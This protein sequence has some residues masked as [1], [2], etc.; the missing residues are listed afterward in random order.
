MPPWDDEEDLLDDDD[1]LADEEEEEWVG[2]G[3]EG[4]PGFRGALFSSQAACYAKFRP[5]YP[6]QVRLARNLFGRRKYA[7]DA[8]GCL[9]LVRAMALGGRSR[10]AACCPTAVRAPRHLQ[11]TAAK[12]TCPELQFFQPRACLCRSWAWSLSAPQHPLCCTPAVYALTACL[13]CPPCKT[14]LTGV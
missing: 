9:A 11:V 3:E 1:L 14:H 12:R 4:R 5:H 2:L 13:A 7:S 6:Q 8:R 10:A